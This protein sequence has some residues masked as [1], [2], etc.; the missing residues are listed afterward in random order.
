MVQLTTLFDDE[1]WNTRPEMAN[2]AVGGVFP[3][4]LT[5]WACSQ[6]EL[7]S[8]ERLQQAESRAERPQRRDVGRLD[9]E[10][11]E[12][13]LRGGRPRRPAPGPLR[14]HGARRHLHGRPR[15]AQRHQPRKFQHNTSQLRSL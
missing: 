9:G 6:A 10:L 3:V 11:P 1:R 12:R 7:S 13:V 14:H 2:G 4:W 15:Q 8:S 5:A